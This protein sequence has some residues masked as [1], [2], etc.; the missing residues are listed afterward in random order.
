[1]QQTPTAREGVEVPENKKLLEINNLRIKFEQD[2]GTVN[3]INGVNLTVEKDELVGIV[4]ESGCGKTVTAYSVMGLIPQNGEITSGE[5]RFNRGGEDLVDICQ[6]DSKGAELRSI[7]GAEVSIIFQEPMNAF[8]PVH[9]LGNQ[10]IEAI[11]THT[12][13]SKKKAREKAIELLDMVRIPDPAQR[14]DDYAFQFSGGMRQRAM[15]AMALACNPQLII[16]DEP[17]SSLDVTIQAQVLGLIKE[18]QKEKRKS[19]LLITHDLGV[20]ANMVEYLYV[21]Y[22]GR[23][24]EEGTTEQVFDNPKHP[25]T[26]DLLKSIPKLKGTQGKLASIEG[27]VPDYLPKGCAFHPRCK[28]KIGEVCSQRVPAPHV[29][30]NGQKASCFKYTDKAVRELEPT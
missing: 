13:H 3:A 9:T 6:L 18:M 29:F 26:R 14:I 17:T 30:S 12:K 24:V 11:L 5:V 28:D 4:G 10:I 16:A 2:E 25:Y 7:R 21:M 15:V 20:I 19:I 22:L 8:S 23:V 1:M 27:S